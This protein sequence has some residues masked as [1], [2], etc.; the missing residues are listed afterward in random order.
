L[1]MT[2]VKKIRRP[3]LALIA[4]S[5]IL[6]AGAAMPKFCL[7]NPTALYIVGQARVL[8]GDRQGGLNLIAYAAQPK[9]QTAT[10]VEVCPRTVK[11]TEA[12]SAAPKVTEQM[13][14]VAAVSGPTKQK[15]I[16]RTFVTPKTMSEA[17]VAKLVQI[18]RLDSSQFAPH[19]DRVKFG[20]EME[21]AEAARYEAQQEIEAQRTVQRVRRDLE[22]RG[23]QIA[24]P[25]APPV[26]PVPSS[27]I[28]MQ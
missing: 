28:Q 27:S 4:G 8:L 26:A 11:A 16:F 24:L 21:R 14:K 7:Q 22:R 5:A 25:P 1:D 6:F 10:T 17:D 20:A 19:F 18:A 2:S 13:K 3:V 23:I 12:K 15:F 9:E